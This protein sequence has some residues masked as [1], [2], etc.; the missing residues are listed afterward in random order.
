[1]PKQS[2]DIFVTFHPLF[3]SLYISILFSLWHKKEL[4]LDGFSEGWLAEKEKKKK[5]KKKDDDRPT[6]G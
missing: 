6:K 4:F 5:N 3:L 2:R 1:M